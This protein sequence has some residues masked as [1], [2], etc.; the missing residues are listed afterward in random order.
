MIVCSTES[1]LMC[2]TAPKLLKTASKTS[3]IFLPDVFAVLGELLFWFASTRVVQSAAG[4]KKR[5]EFE[6][7]LR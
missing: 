3:Q 7:K 2:T 5:F 4:Q 6:K 1:V